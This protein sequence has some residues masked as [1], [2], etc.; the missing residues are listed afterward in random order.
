VAA[1]VVDAWGALG[2]GHPGRVWRFG[3]IGLRAGGRLRP[4]KTHQNGLSADLFV[5]VSDQK[6]RPH[7]LPPTGP[8]HFGYSLEFDQRGRLGALHVDWAALGDLLL[9]L[10]EAGKAH[11]VGIERIIVTPPYQDDLLRARPALAHLQ[12]RFMKKEAWVRHDEHVHVDFT[13]PK[14]ERRPLRCP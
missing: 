7:P 4:H 11:G 1:T 14:E 2:K 5:P 9:A 10:E 13:I 3:D 12:G 6:G 8:P